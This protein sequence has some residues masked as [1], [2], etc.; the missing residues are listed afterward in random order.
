[1]KYT[2]TKNCINWRTATANQM[3]IN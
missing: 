3:H 2:F 1:V